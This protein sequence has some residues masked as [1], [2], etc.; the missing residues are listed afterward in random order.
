MK[1]KVKDLKPNPFRD[2][3]NYPFNMD[4]IDKLKKSIE[5][6]GFWDN[7]LARQ[8]NGDIQIAYGHHR[9]K[10]LQEVY[11]D[12]YMVEVPIKDLSD[13]LMLKIMA[14]ENMEE[15]QSSVAVID[16]TVRA[17]RLFLSQNKNPLETSINDVVAFLNWPESRVNGSFTR[18]NA[19]RKSGI[20]KKAVETLPTAKAATAFTSAVKGK[21]L[22]TGQQRR[23]AK[24]IAEGENYS[25]Q[26]VKLAVEK[27]ANPVTKKDIEDKQQQQL[28]L[29]FDDYLAN[30][31]DIASKL[32]YEVQK[33]RGKKDLIR[34]YK[35]EQ[36]ENRLS[37]K[38]S[39]E[40][41]VIT[42]NN[43]LKTLDNE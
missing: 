43:T 25:P 8:V 10:A 13:E 21:N 5:A 27:E 2:L 24:R 32:K 40:G 26:A 9:L 39:L 18:I 1:V 33:M 41:L 36:F 12:D 16:E 3:E 17:V 7:I 34:N 22:T 31:T 11:S 19:I 42:I 28:I 29:D 4:K 14:N 6:T 20:D 37:L 23:V 35:P 38:L 30:I 15:W